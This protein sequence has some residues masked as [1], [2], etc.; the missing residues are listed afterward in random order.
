MNAASR[1]KNKALSPC[2]RRGLHDSW[3]AE[4]G[5]RKD[6]VSSPGFDEP[7]CE[8]FDFRNGDVGLLAH[9]SELEGRAGEFG[10]D[11]D[12]AALDDVGRDRVGGKGGADARVFEYR[13]AK[14]LHAV[15]V[16]R[17]S[18]IPSNGKQRI[19]GG[20]DEEGRNPVRAAQKRNLVQIFDGPH[21]MALEE[22]G[23]G[24]EPARHDAEVLEC[25]VRGRTR[26]RSD[27]EVGVHDAADGRGVHGGDFKLVLGMIVAEGLD[28]SH[29]EGKKP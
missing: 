6:H 18:E 2:G 13:V 4:S 23:R 26:T 10:K 16:D 22:G 5:G 7:A 19:N 1:A 15:E 12:H 20:G 17:H 11:A 9:E 3:A 29:D 28:R 21:V 27:A 8:S 24:A 25:E 14:S